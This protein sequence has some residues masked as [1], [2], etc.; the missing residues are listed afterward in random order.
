MEKEKYFILTFDIED[1]F[2]S[3]FDNSLPISEVSK[4]NLESLLELLSIYSCKATM[5][6]LGKFALK[7][8]EM[9]K[10]IK[11]EGHE[12][13]SHGFG[14]KSNF[15]LNFKEFKKDL[16]DSKKILEDITGENILGYRAPDFSINEK[17]FYYLNVLGELGFTYDSS[18]FP[19]KLKRYG[20]S[21]FPSYPIKIVLNNNRELY[22][23]PIG[24]SKFYGIKI[25][26]GGGGYH[27]LFPAFFLKMA[28][29]N[30]LKKYKYFV[31]YFHPYEFNYNEF[32]E[33]KIKIP[34]F[35]KI[36]QGI[37]R[38]GMVNKLKGILSSFK[39]YKIED[40]ISLKILKNI[41]VYDVERNKIS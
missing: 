41:E 34:L 35:L 2:Q 32:S 26:T 30:S 14:H 4:K 15:L 20:I 28:I 10:K 33:I 38:K 6:V 3:T 17:N 39:I 11:K 23:F 1:W 31:S 21:N 29:N 16:E 24:T 5:F 36:H 37:G 13:A 18:V 7:F 40:L 22:E 25:P 19:I 27:R 9:V 8:P 12:V